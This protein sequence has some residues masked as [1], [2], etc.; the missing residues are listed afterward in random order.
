M[1]E[2]C[3]LQ[4]ICEKDCPC[5]LQGKLSVKESDE[6]QQRVTRYTVKNDIRIPEDENN[7]MYKALFFETLED[8]DNYRKEKQNS[9]NI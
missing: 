4:P 2:Q 8:A 1:K 9:Q 5:P 7:W 3:P 6:M